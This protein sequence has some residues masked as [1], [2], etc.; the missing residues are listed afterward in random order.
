MKAVVR[1]PDVREKIITSFSFLH[2]LHDYLNSQTDYENS[3]IRPELHVILKKE[4]FE[5][6]RLLPFDVF[7]YDFDS[8]LLKNPMQVHRYCYNLKP[9]FNIDVF[10]DL[11]HSWNSAWMGLCFSAKERVG[12]KSFW[13][14]P[15]LTKKIEREEYLLKPTKEQYLKV[16]STYAPLYNFSNSKI[17]GRDVSPSI[18]SWQE[19]PYLVLNPGEDLLNPC[20]MEQ[21]KEFINCFEEQRF[22]FIGEEQYASHVDLLIGELKKKKNQKNSFINLCKQLSPFE[23][24][25]VLSFAKGLISSNCWQTHVAAYLGGLVFLLLKDTDKENDL[26][27]FPIASVRVYPESDLVRVA[28]EVVK[29]CQ[30]HKAMAFDETMLD[31]NIPSNVIPLNAK[32]A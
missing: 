29:I 14:S 20:K 12:V 3:A 11:E 28:D 31:E 6:L 32:R 1:L 17:M 9:V 15:L 26:P 7:P 25:R 30:L 4:Y 13:R 22:V 19:S 21:W 24:G 16:F 10:F 23:V 8:A 18:D 27:D 2:I 5:L